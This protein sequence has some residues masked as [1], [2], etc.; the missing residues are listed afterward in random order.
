M[1]ALLTNLADELLVQD[2]TDPSPTLGALS[3]HELQ[4]AYEHVLEQFA[5]E[6]LV[7]AHENSEWS[8]G[9]LVI[10]ANIGNIHLLQAAFY[11]VKLE[12]QRRGAAVIVKFPGRSIVIFP[13]A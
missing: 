3:D 8:D 9:K 13:V 10:D 1:N 2:I 5:L 11:A 4:A 6:L 7:G 12:C